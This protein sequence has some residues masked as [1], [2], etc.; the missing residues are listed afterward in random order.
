V[1]TMQAQRKQLIN[2][3]EKGNM[4]THICNMDLLVVVKTECLIC[5]ET[6]SVES[7]NPPSKKAS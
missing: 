3:K 2:Q 4:M 7:L 1:V 6:L 5:N